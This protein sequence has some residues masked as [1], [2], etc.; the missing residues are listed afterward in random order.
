MV[1]DCTIVVKV[2]DEVLRERRLILAHHGAVQ[3]MKKIDSSSL[4]R[5]A[6]TVRDLS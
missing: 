3:R 5:S 4:A 6:Q 1:A 2:L